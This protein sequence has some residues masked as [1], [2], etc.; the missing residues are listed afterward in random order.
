VL[1]WICLFAVALPGSGT[2]CGFGAVGSGFIELK[3]I[4][5]S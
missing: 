4:S 1:K 5:V 2:W 3:S